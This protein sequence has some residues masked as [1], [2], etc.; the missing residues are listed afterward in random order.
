MKKTAYIIAGALALGIFSSC[1]NGEAK[2][3]GK[4]SPE[5]EKKVEK[6]VKTKSLTID[7]EQSQV[8]WSGGIVGGGYGHYGTINISEGSLDVAGDKIVGGNIVIDMKTITPTD[9]SYGDGKTP[10]ML[11]GHLSNEDFFLV[12][13]HPTAT[14]KIKSSDEKSVT[15]DLTIRGITKEYTAELSS[16]EANEDM[17][18]ATGKLVFNRQDFE[19][20]YESTMK[21]ITISNDIELEIS[22]AAK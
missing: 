18:K 1:S 4:E 12:E 9:E 15:G 10:E 2:T 20:S 19:V 6:L 16:V 8:K 22:L 11:V 7:T 5:V 14:F 13:E 3:E 21:D 17:T